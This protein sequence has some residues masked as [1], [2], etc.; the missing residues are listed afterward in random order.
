VEFVYED[1]GAGLSAVDVLEATG[2]N[3]VFLD[4]RRE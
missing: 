2:Q 1:G 3:G 4:Y